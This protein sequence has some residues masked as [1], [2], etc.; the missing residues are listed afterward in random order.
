MRS[1]E[2]AKQH[3]THYLVVAHYQPTIGEVVDRNL[4]RSKG[5]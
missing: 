1:A 2:I 3:L 4:N 5:L